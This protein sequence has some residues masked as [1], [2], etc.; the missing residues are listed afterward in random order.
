MDGSE[1]YTLPTNINHAACSDENNQL[2]SWAWSSD[3]DRLAYVTTCQTS[4]TD[5]EMNWIQVIDAATGE[6]FWQQTIPADLSLQVW[7]P[8]GNHLLLSRQAGPDIEDISIWRLKSDGLD[9]PEMI[10]EQGLFL[11]IIP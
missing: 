7:T 10:I 9:T 5:N 8:D 4:D 2:I 11:D 3:G 6:S 1:L